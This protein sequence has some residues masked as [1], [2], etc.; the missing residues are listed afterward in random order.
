MPLRHETATC[1]TKRSFPSRARTSDS[2]E[3][4]FAVGRALGP[5]AV[6]PRTARDD[7]LRKESSI[8]C[9]LA[10]PDAPTWLQGVSHEPG[11]WEARLCQ[12]RATRPPLPDN[13]RRRRVCGPPAAY[14]GVSNTEHPFEAPGT[15]RHTRRMHVDCERCDVSSASPHTRPQQIRP[16]SQI[17]SVGAAAKSPPARLG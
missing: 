12:V 2:Q 9:T 6:G 5:E 8:S 1:C 14:I 4:A 3:Q 15:R 16:V 7:V 13:P 17:L 11:A 10:S